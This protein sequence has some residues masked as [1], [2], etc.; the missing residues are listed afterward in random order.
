MTTHPIMIER[1]DHGV[2]PAN[3]LG[4]A[5]RFWASFMGA[6]L[7]FLTNMN[8]RGLNREVPMIVFFTV[9]NHAGFGI[10]LQDYRLSTPPARPYEGVVWAFEVA[11]ADLSAAIEEGRKQNLSFKSVDYTATSPVRASLF[12]VDPDGNTIELCVRKEPSTLTP[13]GTVVPL[14]RISHVRIEAT[15][16]D[17]ARAWYSETFGLIEAEQVPGETQLTLTVPKSGQLLILRKVDKVAERSTQCFKGPHI[18]LRASAECYPEIFKRFNRRETYWGPDPN[19]IP[20]HEPDT[21]TA[22][23]YDPF[24]NRIQIGILA[25]RPM[26]FG[27]VTRA[28]PRA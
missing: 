13:Q 14:R 12:V 21:D 11:A 25:R 18:D 24:G 15:D 6:R 5:F 17:L 16:L 22:Y 23:G 19:Q 27:N 9:A 20:W 2:L 10:A 3:D 28:A 1:I 7:N 4:R 8:A 26:T